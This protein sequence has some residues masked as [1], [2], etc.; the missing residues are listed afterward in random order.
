MKLS[1]FYKLFIKAFSK[2]RHVDSDLMFVFLDSPSDYLG[3]IGSITHVKIPYEANTPGTPKVIGF[4]C[5]KEYD[6]IK[7]NGTTA[8]QMA[9]WLGSSIANE[10]FDSKIYVSKKFTSRHDDYRNVP[11][12]IYYPDKIE[13]DKQTKQ[14]IVKC[15]RK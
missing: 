11:D 5:G 4:I 10:L 7:H 15:V 8:K 9:R 6:L 1:E 13:L 2:A 14:I 3:P 12:G